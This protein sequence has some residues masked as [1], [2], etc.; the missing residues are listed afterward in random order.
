MKRIIMGRMR[1]LWILY[2]LSLS[3]LNTS[4][5]RK[6]NT[7]EDLADNNIGFGKTYARHGLFL[8]Y[9]LTHALVF[10]QNNNAIQ[11]ID[12]CTSNGEQRNINIYMRD[13]GLHRF[14]NYENFPIPSD[15]EYRY[16]TVG[17]INQRTYSGVTYFP[18]Y[19]TVD[20]NNRPFA[21]S[22]LDR[23]IL[24]THRN[25]PR[26]ILR[27]FI[28]EHYNENIYEIS[29]QLL[30]EIRKFQN[31]DDFLLKA[32]YNFETR[33]ECSRRGNQGKRRRRSDP[34]CTR[35][36]VMLEV[37]SS[38][39]ANAKITWSN[40]PSTTLRKNLFVRLFADMD[41]T[42]PL[43]S[44]SVGQQSGSID[45]SVPLDNR[46][47]ARL[48]EC[49]NYFCWSESVIWRSSEFD[50]ANR[51][52]PAEVVGYDASLQLFVKKG[53][54]C[55]RLYINKAFTDWRDSFYKAW[56]G[57]YKS[58]NDGHSSYET[59]QWATK[60]NENTQKQTEEEEHTYLIYEYD[61]GLAV[62]QGFQAR[63]FHQKPV[64]SVRA[65][66]VPWGEEAIRKI[67]NNVG[68]YGA[69]LQLT[70]GSDDDSCKALARLYIK[71]DFTDWK[72]T[73]TNSWVGFYKSSSDCSS[74]YTT[75]QWVTSF[76][77]NDEKCTEEYM[78]YDYTSSMTV[79]H[80]VE[81]RFF[82][83]RDYSS[84]IGQAV[85][86]VNQRLIYACSLG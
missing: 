30:E 66:T 82:L 71:R 47:Q 68:E 63:L 18:N 79:D 6:L 41:S 52:F 4:D 69:S 23:L 33:P 24:Q 45:T 2:L 7:I 34:E 12:T 64:L 78:A 38:A 67:Q 20:F 17:N 36:V 46:L 8:L 50:D 48:S 84:R 22:N 39:T 72:N 32:G 58:S 44:F 26:T 62:Q 83:S 57:F 74:S 29:P 21:E 65:H 70:A 15:S 37:R 1:I 19:V 54:A 55:A 3:G 80:G 43:Y 40:I 13:Y 27:V 51:K 85:L 77:R 11:L 42:K 25:N 16:L 5:I 76:V 73:L 35:E 53:K 28:T 9:W 81:A 60:F 10:N 49:N 86:D 31:L 14:N 75:Y 56:V 59:Y 61:S